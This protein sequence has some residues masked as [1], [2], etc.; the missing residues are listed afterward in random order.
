[1]FARECDVVIL[2]ATLGSTSI[3][4]CKAAIDE[5]G[6]E[7]FVGAVL[8]TPAAKPA[9]VNLSVAREA[10]ATIRMPTTGIKS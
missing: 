2:V 3:A 9:V 6:R 7:R 10:R 5:I 8:A 1:M 4:S